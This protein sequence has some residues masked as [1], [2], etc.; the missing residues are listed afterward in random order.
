MTGTVYRRI[1][2]TTLAVIILASGAFLATHDVAAQR[3]VRWQ[4]Y[5]VSLDIQPDG[6]IDVAEY[7]EIEFSGGPFSGGFAEIPLD[8]IDSLGNVRISQVVDGGIDSYVYVRPAGYDGAA[9][10][11]TVVQ[12]A[13]EALIDY[14]FD[15]V[16]NQTLTILLEYTVNGV[17]RTYPDLDP[18]NQQL[19]WTAIGS[20]VTDIADI[21]LA[22]VAIHLPQPVDPSETIAGSEGV[23]LEYTIA[24][25]QVWTWTRTNMSS[26]DDLIVRLQFPPVTSASEPSWQAR[27]DQQA[28]DAE[29]A[30]ERSA[31]LNL[32][33]LA[34]GG[35]GAIAGG[36]ALYGLWYLRGRDP[37]SPPAAAF[38][39]APPDTLAPGAV[40][41]LL[42]EIA[43][44]RDIIATLLDLA[45]RNILTLE[46]K[47][48]E[49]VFGRSDYS[50]TL[51]DVPAELR[52]FEMTLLRSLFGSDLETGKQVNFSQ[53]KSRF[54][55]SSEQIRTQLYEEVV[56]KGYFNRGPELTRA[57]WRTWSSRALF[58]I[59]I[60]STVLIIWF[61]GDSSA[62]WL[63]PIV[64]VILALILR[65]L[66]KHMP[67]KTQAGADAAENWRS[68]QRYLDEIEK[69][70]AIASHTEVFEKY[71]PFV[72]SFGIEESWVRK[73]AD[74][75]TPS[76]TWFEPAGGGWGSPVP[77]GGST[78]R[79]RG[80]VIVW[81]D[82]GSGSPGKRSS[83]PF[84]ETGGGGGSGFPDAGDLQ[85]M[86][87]SAQRRLSSTSSSLFDMLSSAAEAFASSSSGGGGGR[88]GGGF[89]GGFG[90]SRGGGGFSGGGSRG[91]SS[92]GGGRGFR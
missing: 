9:G 25:D 85:D 88:S 24:D 90:G 68:F 71:L 62:V 82:S 42:D 73:F 38:I 11:Y 12:T 60:V 64:A 83:R 58:A 34:I 18:P 8:R 14:G 52:P 72:V 1:A 55:A 80:P 54:A 78:R 56:A 75:N 46:E 66:S 74:V 26:G 63:V 15:S 45:G 39:T 7:Q 27:L 3:S 57:A 23:D 6:T 4:R 30:E 48:Q 92:G 51:V 32:L 53:V 67:R 69:Y 70:E 35:F 65:W 79:G 22:T 40:G 86:S 21:D 16:S 31:L 17:I 76:P 47:P 41:T 91:G 28:V 5:D 19:W 20:E 13:S 37:Y 77:G 36:I 61:G 33:F 2:L 50:M 81:G 59:A 43:Q 44:D 49:G 10:T 84:P 29:K 87:D 89:G